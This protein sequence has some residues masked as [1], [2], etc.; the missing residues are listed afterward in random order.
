[1]V[2]KFFFVFSYASIE[3][4]DQAVDCRVHVLFCCVSVN[5]TT[6][7]I[8]GSFRL[9]PQFLNCEDAVH[10]GHEIKMPSDFLDLAFNITSESIGHFDMMA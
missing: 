3:F 5:R 10:A 2:N 6:I 4:I 8:N 1:M 7:Y 9:V